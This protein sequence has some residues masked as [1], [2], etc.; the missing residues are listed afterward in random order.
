[1][2]IKQTLQNSIEKLESRKIPSANI[3]AEVLLLGALN[4]KQLNN[5]IH[6]SKLGI[7]T[8]PYETSGIDGWR[9]TRSWLYA[10]NDYELTSEESVLF[11]SYINRRI[12]H[13]PVAYIINKKEFY[14]YEFFI[15]GNVLIPRPETELIVENVLQIINERKDLNNKFTLIDIGT[16]SGCILISILNEFKKNNN[17][18]YINQSIAIDISKRAI[19]IAKINAKKYNLEKNIKY[20]SSDFKKIINQKLFFNSNNFIITANLP[21]ISSDNYEKLD[22]SVKDFEPKLALTAGIDGLDEIKK[23]LHSIS[24][25]KLQS[26]QILYFLLE[27]DPSQINFIIKLLD[28]Y[29]N[30]IKSLIIKDLS[31]KNRI[32][33]LKISF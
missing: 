23:L 12:K 9:I 25:I 29:F 6:S 4:K 27:V 11:D 3:D 26:N 16:G 17:L 20:I 15:N 1:M 19:E 21:Y 32:I 24:K 7:A 2:N 5:N 18:K 33:V 31:D 10:H 22:N 8:M 13:E 28:K 30:D 14:G